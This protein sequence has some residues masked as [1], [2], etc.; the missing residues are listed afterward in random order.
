MSINNM[1]R[2]PSTLLALLLFKCLNEFAM[3]TTETLQENSVILVNLL[4][5]RYFI[6]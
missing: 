2:R 6:I 4:E 3:L 5:L 1:F